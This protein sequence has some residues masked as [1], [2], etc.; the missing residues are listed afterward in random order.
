LRSYPR[1]HDLF[2]HRVTPMMSMQNKSR[3]AALTPSVS[4]KDLLKARQM[5][6]RNRTSVACAR[7][8]LAKSR[9]TEYRPCKRCVNSS[10]EC[11]QP[12]LYMSSTNVGTMIQA[13]DIINDSH[14]TPSITTFGASQQFVPTAPYLS[15]VARRNESHF[16]I[17]LHRESFVIGGSA[18]QPFAFGQ[19]QAIQNYEF[20]GIHALLQQSYNELSN[21][22]RLTS[23]FVEGISRVLTYTRS[24]I[25]TQVPPQH[26][27]TIP[28]LPAMQTSCAALILPAAMALLSAWATSPPPTLALLHH[29]LPAFALPPPAAY[30]LR[31]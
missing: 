31:R 4:S 22:T 19:Q 24:E 2:F 17:D 5:A 26:P 8:K 25:Q 28:F 29:L 6:K 18:S 16:G 30:L 23:H 15:K 21:K 10:V 11:A 12:A 1:R 14:S 27:T 7:C 9:C 3:S 13:A 20:M